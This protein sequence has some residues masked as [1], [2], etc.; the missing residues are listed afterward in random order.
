[1]Q[2]NIGNK[3][4]ID[5]VRLSR[6]KY[7]EMLDTLDNSRSSP[8]DS[9]RRNNQRRACQQ[10]AGLLL[11]LE[12]P[13]GARFHFIVRPRDISRTGMGFLHGGYVHKGTKAAVSLVMLDREVISR[14]GAVVRCRHVQGLIHEVGVKFDEPFETEPF[15]APDLSVLDAAQDGSTETK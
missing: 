15:A 11:E 5:S 13:T 7:L 3:T 6:D 9:N 12:H 10:V 2:C 8:P 1:M 4:Y 14:V